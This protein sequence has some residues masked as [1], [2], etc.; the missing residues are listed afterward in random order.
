LRLLLDTHVLIW[1]MQQPERLSPTAR[2]ALADRQNEIFVSAA[3][4]WEIAIKV[5]SGRLA[6][7]VAAI[8]IMLAEMGFGVVE[9]A[10]RHAVELLA[11]PRLHGDPFDR[12]LIAQARAEGLTL[13][14]DDAMIRQYDVALL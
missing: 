9:I 3:S 12:M 8:D 5:A 11:L 1:A 13:V 6:F 10:P 4:V 14:S 2:T 7:P